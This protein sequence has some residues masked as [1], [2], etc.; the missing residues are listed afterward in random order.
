MRA[1]RAGASSMRSHWCCTTRSGGRQ[2]LLIL[3]VHV[4]FSKGN[5]P[6]VADDNLAHVLLLRAL[7]SYV[8]C[9]FYDIGDNRPSKLRKE[10]RYM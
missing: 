1:R 8:H 9:Y 7:M 10:G 4:L 6:C 2:A 3:A 5:L